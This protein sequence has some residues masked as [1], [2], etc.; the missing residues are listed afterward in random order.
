MGLAAATGHWGSGGLSSGRCAGRQQGDGGT[1]KQG[2]GDGTRMLQPTEFP[3]ASGGE[4]VC[5]RKPRPQLS[6]APRRGRSRCAQDRVALP[7]RG[8]KPVVRS[9]RPSQGLSPAQSFGLSAGRS[10]GTCPASPWPVSPCPVSP[11]K[12]PG[13]APW[14]RGACSFPSACSPRNEL[15]SC[16]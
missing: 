5:P 3:V 10:G 16:N 6:L 8:G 2:H 11:L 9:R 7:S 4:T 12:E 15:M 1:G 13:W 14:A